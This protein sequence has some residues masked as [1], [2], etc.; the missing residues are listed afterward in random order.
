MSSAGDGQ[1]DR[2]RKGG[3]TRALNFPL[4]LE[5]V[6]KRGSPAKPRETLRPQRHLH[7]S[8][9]DASRPLTLQGGLGL[10]TA[11][12]RARMVQ[13]LRR[14]GQRCEPV[15]AAMQ[16]VPRH[17]FV[18]TAL[19]AQAYEDTSLPIGHG[20]T[21]S[22]P[23]V[24]ARMVE[25]LYG[26][27]QATALGHL[28]RTLEVGTGCGYQT[29]L[30]AQLASWLVSIE[31]LLP[32]HEKALLHLADAQ[33]AAGRLDH[34]HLL[35]GD[36]MLGHACGAPFDTIIAA[37]GGR[38]TPQAWLDQ[39][40]VGGRLVAPVHGVGGRGQVLVVVDRHASGWARSEHEGVHF[41]PLKSGIV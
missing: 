12:V 41:V 3:A 8:A 25:L 24:V 4:P 10:D 30:L 15:L 19:A 2:D 13:R 37:A 23:S 26:G 28:G 18:D 33:M 17:L 35:H 31:R 9:R 6:G 22:K 40:A 16:R 29:A 7:E 1:G 38:E 39:L 14:E 27:A 36:G 34:L 5:R 11:L 20:Q 32:L 21:I